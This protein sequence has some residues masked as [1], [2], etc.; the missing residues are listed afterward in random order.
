MTTIT[1][2][3][4]SGSDKEIS[5]IFE[6]DGK[7]YRPHINNDNKL[8]IYNTNT[9]N[10]EF[11]SNNNIYV[12]DQQMKSKSF[13]LNKYYTVGIKLRGLK[14]DTQFKITNNNMEVT[15]PI[16]EDIEKYIQNAKLNDK[17]S[18]VINP[19]LPIFD[20]T[21]M[22]ELKDKNFFANDF[23]IH[24]YL[25][26]PTVY[27][28]YGYQKLIGKNVH[29]K[30]LES[31]DYYSHVI[32]MLKKHRNGEEGYTD[33]STVSGI[34]FLTLHLMIINYNSKY[35]QDIITNADGKNVV[36]E[37]IYTL[38]NSKQRINTGNTINTLYYMLQLIYINIINRNSVFSLVNTSTLNQNGINL[39]NVVDNLLKLLLQ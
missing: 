22:N 35:T 6:I 34:L 10:V 4:F 18:E 3:I 20:L 8:C 28:M 26:N 27:I 37:L 5:P 11:K 39:E 7:E 38:P 9:V 17:I 19:F 21:K 13:E 33:N 36:H 12:D 31:D 30:N 1:V 16:S 23:D 24:K 32:D 25:S 14:F 2:K 15:K 29:V